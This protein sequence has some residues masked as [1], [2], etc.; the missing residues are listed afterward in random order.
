MEPAAWMGMRF[1]ASGSEGRFCAQILSDHNEY[2]VDSGQELLIDRSLFIRH[3]ARRGLIHHHPLD[4]RIVVR[5][6]PLYCRL[7]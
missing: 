6:G 5:F 2:L 4:G 3:G 1:F 7:Q